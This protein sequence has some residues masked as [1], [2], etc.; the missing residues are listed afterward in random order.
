MWRRERAARYGVIER[1]NN[2]TWVLDGVKYNGKDDI[3][4]AIKNDPALMQSLLE[5]SKEAKK[6]Y[7]GPVATNDEDAQDNGTEDLENTEE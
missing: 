1:P 3:A 2:K 6:N 7:N 5:R 4:T